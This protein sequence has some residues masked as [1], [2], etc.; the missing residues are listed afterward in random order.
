[1]DGEQ[2]AAEEVALS[3]QSVL[4]R[5][6]PLTVLTKD[7]RIGLSA[8]MARSFPEE[9]WEGCGLRHPETEKEAR[10]AS[11]NKVPDDGVVSTCK[12]VAQ[13]VG[14]RRLSYKHVQMNAEAAVK[15]ERTWIALAHQSGWCILDVEEAHDVFSRHAPD[16]SLPVGGPRYTDLID[17]LFTTSGG[18]KDQ[19]AVMRHLVVHRRR[20]MKRMSLS[21]SVLRQEV[22]FPEF[23]RA[24][25][26]WLGELNKRGKCPHRDRCQ[27]SFCVLAAEE[28][29]RQK[30]I[31]RA[32]RA[33]GKKEAKR[34]RATNK[35]FDRI[36]S[37]LLELPSAGMVEQAPTQAPARRGSGLAS[38]RGSALGQP[39]APSAWDTLRS[40]VHD[41]VAVQHA[42]A[43]RSVARPPTRKATPSPMTLGKSISDAIESQLEEALPLAKNASISKQM[44]RQPTMDINEPPP[45][46]MRD[47]EIMTPPEIPTAEVDSRDP[48]NIV[49]SMVVPGRQASKLMELLEDHHESPIKGIERLHQDNASEASSNS[50]LWS[51]QSSE[52]GSSDSYESEDESDDQSSGWGD[53]GEDQDDDGVAEDIVCSRT[54]RG[55]VFEA[56]AA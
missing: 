44:R 14:F 46:T 30:E 12:Y 32:S 55:G 3:P 18:D 1:V 37:S 36:R 19:D 16:G 25:S 41:A 45:A 49:L 33:A 56:A 47:P 38:K 4:R 5:G 15:Q 17:N 48:K 43:R 7:L 50:G 13:N 10:Q 23:F 28:A 51:D 11:R 20:R 2:L 34:R 27:L 35:H 29:A 8:S 22:R 6:D 54:R 24:L 52:S 40:K 26:R 31:A 53:S 39:S 42:V 9:A 21:E